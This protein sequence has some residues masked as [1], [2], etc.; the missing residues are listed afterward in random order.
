MTIYFAFYLFLCIFE[1]LSK[2]LSLENEN[3]YWIYFAFCS[4]IRIFA[5]E[6]N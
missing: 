4:F 5:D 3:K 1:L 2:I 6:E